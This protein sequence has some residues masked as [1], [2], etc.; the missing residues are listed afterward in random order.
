M[1][2]SSTARID[3]P[4]TAARPSRSVDSAKARDA[5]LVDATR[6]FAVEQARRTRWNI[7]TTWAPLAATLVIAGTHLPWP[8]RLIASVGASLLLVRG[9]ILF[10]DVLHGAIVK[11]SPVVRPLFDL[12]GILVLTPPRVWRQTHNYHH[13]HTAQLVGSHVGSFP[14]VSTEMWAEMSRWQRARYL[15]ARHP[16]TIAV[17]YLTVF[18]YGMCVSSFL[19][20]PK[21]HWDSALA[22]VV[23]LAL[24][25]GLYVGLGPAGYVFCMLIPI[26]LAHA[27][28]AYLF[29]AQHN[30]PDVEVEPRESWSYGKAALASSSYMPMGMVMQWFTGNIGYHHVH[31]LNPSIP[32]YRLPEA[33]AAIPELADPGVTRLTFKEIRA[34]FRLKLWDAEAGQMVEVPKGP[35]KRKAEP[36]PRLESKVA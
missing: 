26:A 10:H 8:I 25:V 5:A 16:A 11:R 21:K 23:H 2:Q 27:M 31:H 14:M 18:F 9:F 17:A 35:A 24:S 30:F 6:P 28:G 34:A 20:D 33:M 32:F 22:I 29:Y 3:A 36:E 12:F 1:Q 19:R 7:A 13:A 15:I 4:L